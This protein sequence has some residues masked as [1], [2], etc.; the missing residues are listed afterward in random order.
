MSWAPKELLVGMHQPALSHGGQR[1]PERDV[2]AAAAK[3]ES[4]AARSHGPGGYQHHVRARAVNGGQLPR[5]RTDDFR[6]QVT[7]AR[8]DVGAGLDDYAAIPELPLRSHGMRPI[9]SPRLRA[10]LP[11]CTLPYCP[12]GPAVA[13]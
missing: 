10:G 2:A 11:R 7:A 6:V 12:R 5:Q 9:T 1:L 3:A 13:R 4:V 8:Q